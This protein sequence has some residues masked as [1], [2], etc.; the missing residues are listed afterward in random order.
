MNAPSL[1]VRVALIH[2]VLQ[3]IADECGARLLHIKGPAVAAELPSVD[4]ASCSSWVAGPRTPR[5]W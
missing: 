3:R 5:F 1:V 2:G 4:A